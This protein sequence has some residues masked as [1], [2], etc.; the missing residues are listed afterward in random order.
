VIERVVENWLS[1]INERQY[2]IP[3]CQ[4]LTAEGEDV[5]VISSHGQLEQGKDVV[6]V[7]NGV[8][9]AYQLK[10]GDIALSD[11]QKY[12]SEIVML[13]EYKVHGPQLSGFEEHQSIL[14]TN[15]RVNAPAEA[16][17][18]SANLA[19]VKRGFKPLIVV[20][21]SSLVTR[22][23]AAHGRFLP[24]GLT[25]FNHFLSLYIGDGT[26]PRDKS[27]HS[28]MLQGILELKE[29]SKELS[30]KD[31]ERAA[32]SAV[33]IN[34]YV[35]Q[36]VL[37]A[38]NHWSIFEAWVLTATHIRALYIRNGINTSSYSLQICLSSAVDA[39][40][41]L[42][43]ECV[44]SDRTWTVPYIS[45]GHIYPARIAILAGLLSA[46]HL[47][48]L[49]RD[50]DDPFQDFIHEFLSSHLAKAKIWGESAIPYIVIG[51]LGLHA[52]GEP[53]TATNV[54][55]GHM[56]GLAQTN[57]RPGVGLFNTYWGPEASLK[58]IYGMDR[59]STEVFYGQSYTLETLIQFLARRLDLRSLAYFWKDITE[60][61]FLHFEPNSPWE[62]LLW[63]SDHG[64]LRR[65]QPGRPEIW[66]SL[67]S[68]ASKIDTNLL[69]LFGND[70]AF[71]LMF[72][73]VY[74]HRWTAA[75]FRTVDE[76]LF[77]I[78]TDS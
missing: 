42:T 39:L 58:R 53:A 14:V 36:P 43:E 44:K 13:V 27:A 56:A 5:R 48:C 1:V 51:A 4:L 76:S 65:A 2:Q 8:L 54:I 29:D 7:V 15:G 50:Q 30:K 57:G 77:P 18:E 32:A 66:D 33:L 52:F 63:R 75:L 3:F 28:R 62:Y 38:E 74:H 34:S 35:I 12:Y 61:D 68:R 47:I 49:I 17:I 6:S 60:V 73:L 78:S 23:C 24:T 64:I 25:D 10:G 55:R 46:Y 37:V 67:L 45:D 21:R 26:A 71:L 16:A 9:R 59:N 22:F 40:R 20:S 70:L 41:A 31:V 11:W 72:G 69:D 19:W